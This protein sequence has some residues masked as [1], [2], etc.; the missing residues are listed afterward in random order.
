MIN[1]IMSFLGTL[2]YPLFSILFI[3]IDGIQSLF[4]AFAGTGTIRYG[5]VGVNNS[6]QKITGDNTGAETDTGIVYYLFQS[7]LIRNVFMS[8]LILAV[9]LIII[10]TVMA[11]IKNAYASKQ[12]KWQEI[13]GN[14]FIGLANFIFI[15]VCCL[16]GVW[17]GNILL[18]AIDG[19][20]NLSGA[21]SMSRQLFLSSSYNANEF[22]CKGG[23]ATLLSVDQA[24]NN[25]VGLRQ[26][27]ADKGAEDVATIEIIKQEWTDEE[28]HAIACEYYAEKVDEIYGTEGVDIYS[29][30]SVS[31][32]YQLW[33]INYV[34]LAG[35]GGFIL[36]ALGA[37]TFG[38]VKRMF[39]LLMLFV[40]S[41]AL[42]ALYPL[43]DGKAVGQWKGDFVKN[44][45]SAY[46]A[47]AGLNLFFSIAPIIQNIK[48]YSSGGIGFM[49][50][51]LGITSLILTICGLYVVKDFISMI[52]GYIGAGNAY[53]D[54]ASLMSNVNKRTGLGNFGKGSIKA[55]SKAAGA[56]KAAESGKMKAFG[57]SL[58]KS[59]GMGS[60]D[61]LKNT[62]GIDVLGSVKEF[63]SSY[64]EGQTGSKTAKLLEDLKKAKSD[65]E[66]AKSEEGKKAAMDKIQ[67]LTAALGLTSLALEK[68][69]K[70]INAS[71]DQ[72]KES[73]SS[74]KSVDIALANYNQG[75]KFLEDFNEKGY[76]SILTNFG[77]DMDNLFGAD[78][79]LN[80]TEKKRKKEIAMAMLRGVSL[81][82]LGSDI[83]KHMS[84][85]AKQA[86]RNVA[87]QTAGYDP[88][89]GAVISAI[90]DSKFIGANGETKN[91]APHMAEIAAF[92]RGGY[93]GLEDESGKEVQVAN[94]D[95]LIKA[96]EKGSFDK[97][98]A[99][100]KVVGS[101][102]SE[103][104][105]ML[106]TTL[107]AN[108]KH[109]KEVK[110]A[111][112]NI[113]AAKE[114]KKQ[115]SKK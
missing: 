7:T 19:A 63:S 115:Q 24:Y 66:D 36:Y 93:K 32:W 25:V 83:T 112:R 17:L 18:K 47:V 85:E 113:E 41:P 104:L 44:T 27:W 14:A 55:I 107:Q 49:M 48:L 71:P 60:L 62:T 69:A 11:F 114:V 77:I 43:D 31:D 56:F 102:L 40:I 79:D 37:I 110:E 16:L 59:T 4:Q 99:D 21:A 105:E 81:E 92:I 90:R 74:K 64:K 51:A 103:G 22:R 89:G 26:Y 75:L 39:M 8:I 108:A 98:D 72:L 88:T 96:F 42:C 13:V 9:F 23:D 97:H 78:E 94:M 1:A 33:Q 45:I 35:G 61:L 34:L 2:I 68:V 54:G 29:Y 10:F 3:L 101:T 57:G 73:I 111:I 58:L 5:G 50:D 15:P 53:G 65:Y 46:G 20:T 86:Y 95:E 6:S 70:G 67:Q 82:D 84:A 100:G 52:S 80:N 30:W 76:E 87:G 28:Q 106:I 109:D 91:F 12:K 38:M